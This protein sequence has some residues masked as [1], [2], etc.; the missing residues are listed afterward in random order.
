MYYLQ[1]RY[2][3]PDTGRF[4]NADD[5]AFLGVIGTVLSCNLFAY[6]ENNPVNYKDPSGNWLI[7]VISGIAGAAVFGTVANILCRLLGV[8]TTVRRLITAGFALLGG[9]LGA[10][11]GPSIVG[12]I[13][14]NALEWVKKL[15]KTINSNSNFR[16]IIFEGQTIIGFEYNNFK[17]MLHPT[18]KKEPQKGWHIAIQHKTKFGNWRQTIPD[19]PLKNLGKE[20]MNWVKKWLK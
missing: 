20:F 10:A 8:N 11:F 3:D 1:S 2:Y 12:K 14:P 7:Q 15:E 4:I 9:I 16:P 13:A 18:H 6:C 19:I 5:V 17:I